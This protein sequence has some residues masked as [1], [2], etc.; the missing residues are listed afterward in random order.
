MKNNELSY[1]ARKTQCQE[2][3]RL[4]KI[5]E[6]T[7]S[8]ETE[9][10]S[11]FFRLHHID[12]FSKTQGE[13]VLTYRVANSKN[14]NTKC[15]YLVTDSNYE[16]I[17]FRGCYKEIPSTESYMDQNIQAACRYAIDEPI[18]RPLRKECEFK[19]RSGLV[20]KSAISSQPINDMKDL[21]IDHYDRT[22]YEVV[23]EFINLEGREFLFSKINMDEHKSS[24]TKF[25]DPNIN[26]RFVSFHNAN[27]HLRIITKTEN[28]SITKQSDKYK[29]QIN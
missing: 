26:L 22:F 13:D 21:H 25:T 1:T 19:L 3:L 10:L 29:C 18:I 23:C 6:T 5:G 17:G 12:W 27:T 15:L 7:T 14:H 2:I 16:D 8:E 24:V 11:A 28:L 9:L 4:H 20:I